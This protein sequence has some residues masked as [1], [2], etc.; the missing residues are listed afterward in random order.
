[1]CPSLPLSALLLPVLTPPHPHPTPHPTSPRRAHFCCSSLWS[2][3]AHF[4]GLSCAC[5]RLWSAPQAPPA[6]GSARGQG[7]GAPCGWLQ[8]LAAPPYVGLVM[9]YVSGGTL[10]DYAKGGLPEPEAQWFFQQLLIG[11][12]YCHRRG[13]WSSAWFSNAM[14]WWERWE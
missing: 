9:E 12:D 3:C 13:G 2:C 10:Y 5:P 14:M 6:R 11:L 1:M 7:Q 8:V 4:V